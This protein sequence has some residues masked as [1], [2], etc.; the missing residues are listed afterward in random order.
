[1]CVSVLGTIN[2]ISERPSSNSSTVQ[3]NC[4]QGRSTSLTFIST[5]VPTS[6]NEWAFKASLLILGV[7][8]E[9]HCPNDPG[10][11]LG[12]DRCE[13][14]KPVAQA[15]TWHNTLYIHLVYQSMHLP[16]FS[17]AVHRCSTL[18]NANGKP[19]QLKGN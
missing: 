5:L 1:M 9:G 3:Y 12:S 14:S 7:S 17:K 13:V 2:K 4:M 15:S 19:L 6:S 16:W 10:Q 11:V 18:G 8:T